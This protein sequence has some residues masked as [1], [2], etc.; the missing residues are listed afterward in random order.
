[1]SLNGFV[2]KQEDL[3]GDL[4]KMNNAINDTLIPMKAKAIDYGPGT[5]DSSAL[6]ENRI[7]KNLK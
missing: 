1:M 2:L 5:S 7:Q 3:L 6:E 4:M